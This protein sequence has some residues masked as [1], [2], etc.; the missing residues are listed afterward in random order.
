MRLHAFT[1]EAASE[2]GVRRSSVSFSAI[3]IVTA[4]SRLRTKIT[5]TRNLR[6]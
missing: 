6:K 5:E 3:F 2:I 1:N 4:D